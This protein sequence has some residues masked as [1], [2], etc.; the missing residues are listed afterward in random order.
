MMIL[1][2]RDVVDDADDVGDDDDDDDD[3]VADVDVDVVSL[4]MKLLHLLY[5]EVAVVLR[6]PAG[7]QVL[8]VLDHEFDKM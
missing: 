8:A 3:D 2:D 6:S 7:T 4:E 1:L 5:F